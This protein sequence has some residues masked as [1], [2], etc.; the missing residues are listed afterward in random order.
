M[1][2]RSNPD[3]A[4][5]RLLAG[6]GKH[7]RVFEEVAVEAV[8]LHRYRLLASPGLLDGLAAG[9][10][11]DRR[12]DGSYVVVTRS[13]NLCIQLWYPNQDL[14]SRVDGELLPD[15]QEL[16]GW[17]DGRSPGVSVF[18]V[19]LNATFARIEPVFDQWVATAAGSGWSFANVYADDG[20]T[21]LG[22]WESPDVLDRSGRLGSD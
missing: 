6:R 12:D 2:D 8:S 15:V 21:P 5:V 18:T 11:F 16:G 10:V 3:Q 13:G 22:W 1:L 19:P 20:T 17:L 14:H 4:T 9:D 7:E